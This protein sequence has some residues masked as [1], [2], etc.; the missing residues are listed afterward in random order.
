M[1]LGSTSH[2]R[3]TDD[4]K[5]QAGAVNELKL[6]YAELAQQ[7]LTEYERVA[8]A[9][10][11]VTGA[12]AEGKREAQGMAGGLGGLTH[13]KGALIAVAAA[14]ASAGLALRSFNQ[15]T[16]RLDK[17]AKDARKFGFGAEELQQLDHMATLSG[18]SVDNVAKASLK[19]NLNLRAIA[20][21]GGKQ[22]AGALRDIGVN[23]DQLAGMSTP[24]RLA[25]LADKLNGVDDKGKRAAIAFELFGKSGTQLL[26][27]LE[28]GSAGI[29]EM[30]N[31]LD[32]TFTA[33]ELARI[34]QYEDEVT[35]FNKQASDL[36]TE[37][38]IGLAPAATKTAEAL[39]YVASGWAAIA[40]GETLERS[41]RAMSRLLPWL[42][43]ERQVLKD[44]ER[45][46]R[47]SLSLIEQQS[48]KI[49]AFTETIKA[50]AEG[51]D[52]NL[53]LLEQ[54]ASWAE[55][56]LDLAIAQGLE[57]EKLEDAYS[58]QYDAKIALL[59]ATGDQV[60][61]EAA[62]RAETVRQAAA[63]RPRRRG[64]R[65]PS[66]AQRLEAEGEA[67]LQVWTE[68][69][70]LAELTAEL[71]GEAA[72]EAL[73]L[74]RVRKDL[75]IQ[76]LEL[77]RQVLEVTR[78]RNSVERQ[79]NETKIA[80]I[81]ATIREL[82]LEQQLTEQ[83]YA[84]ADAQAWRDEWVASVHAEQQALGNVV[85]LE[86]YRLEQRARQLE[87]EGLLG[88]VYA[89]R[90]EQAQ[91][92]ADAMLAELELREQLILAQ[93][94]ETEADR[95]RQQMELDQLAHAQR[96]T[97]AK[98]DSQTRQLADAESKRLFAMERARKD[99]SLKQALAIAQQVS[100]VTQAGGEL[101]AF[102]AEST[103][104]DEEKRQ[105]VI[106]GIQGGIMLIEGAVNVGKAA[107]SYAS[108]NIPQG[109]A[110]TAA[111]AINFAK[112]GML[113][114]GKIPGAGG[115]GVSSGGGA[116]APREARERNTSDASRVPESVPAAADRGPRQLGG[117][118]SQGQ[119]GGVVI[120][121]QGD[122]A[123]DISDEFAEKMV[124]A[125]RNVGYRTG[126]G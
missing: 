39:G 28:A 5:A 94:P 111:A 4:A 75:T 35:R 2:E 85:E 57:G 102:V 38:V 52:E 83:R 105:R 72:N 118:G 10:R 32:R 48:E 71:S 113:M 120:N 21:G 9:Q 23:A 13:A 63:S 16:E 40:R 41:E 90:L 30:N 122:V 8:A 97:I 43:E 123:G 107:T 17:L 87:S 1:A 104:K 58:R 54:Q 65:G 42:L 24:E 60:A 119:Q 31:E 80:V 12:L 15:E 53:E 79:Q 34:E 36:K 33:A 45:S 126:L 116:A 115:G 109:I 56:S 124:L 82:E 70:R 88:E 96:M 51:E 18:T 25:F 6:V 7:Q 49:R 84:Q 99:A 69:L 64:G 108:L 92:Q 46:R 27:M 44:S 74:G 95:I 117:E 50:R 14:A 3:Y 86:E 67:M 61:L 81:D 59:R 73:Y 100:D 47:Y 89:V 125:Q 101:A 19:L 55:H 22:A 11:K 62:L 77:D 29:R 26:P 112:G 76:E 66:E 106:M 78:A 37:L 93:D 110:H 121:I 91:A 20:D 98:R 114:S 103:I 68:Q